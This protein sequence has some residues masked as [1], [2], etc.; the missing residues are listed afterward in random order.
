[1]EQE[2]RFCELDGR[3]IAY[4]TVGE[5]PPLVFAS[6]WISHLEDEW[7]EPRFRAFLE[8]LARGHRVVRYDRLGVG[9]SDRGLTGP[10]SIESEARALDTVLRASSGDQAAVIFACSCAGLAASRFAADQPDRVAKLVFFGGYAARDDIPEAT[11]RSLVDFVRVN[12]MLASQMLAGL[13]VPHGSIER[14]K[15]ADL[16][17]YDGDCFENATHVTNTI[18]NGR[19]AYD[20]AE[21][22]A[23][24]L[25]RRAL[26]LSGGETSC[27]LGVW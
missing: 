14:G 25:A 7:V 12:W 27:C 6:R 3:R 17:L 20:R 10:P 23:I 24:P 26:S 19:V 2:I 21:V 1:M 18:V 5:G 8:E 16:V 9:L 11:R 13:F 4:A 15:V 22:Q